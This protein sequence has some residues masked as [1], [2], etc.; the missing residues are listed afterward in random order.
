MTPTTAFV[1]VMDYVVQNW[2]NGRPRGIPQYFSSMSELKMYMS[3]SN[4]RL[5]QWRLIRSNENVPDRERDG[6]I[7]EE[8]RWK[9]TPLDSNPQGTRVFE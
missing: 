2:S 9:R 5:P 3:D 8:R 4:G 6:L 7:V 1:P